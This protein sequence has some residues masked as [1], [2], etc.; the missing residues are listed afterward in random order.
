MPPSKHSLPRTI[1]TDFHFWLPVAVL[2]FGIGLLF[3]VA[4][5]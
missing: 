1:V 4:R 3:F 5:S 2:L